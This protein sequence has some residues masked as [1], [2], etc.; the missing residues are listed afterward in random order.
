MHL[1][2]E[3]DNKPFRLFVQRTWHAMQKNLSLTP[4]EARVARL[5]SDHPEVGLFFPGQEIDISVSYAPG[6]HNPFL[7]LAA[8]R[9]VQQQI[10]QEK[11]AG[12]QQLYANLLGARLS[13]PEARSRMASAYLEWY[14]VAREEPGSHSDEAY[15]LSLQEHIGDPNTFNDPFAFAVPGQ[16][17]SPS[18][19]YMG[20]VFDKA[21]AALRARMYE[22]IS[23]VSLS[24]EMLLADIL[25]RLPREWVQAT[26][27]YWRLPKRRLKR[28]SIKD[29]CRWFAAP[30]AAEAFNSALSENEQSCL[31]HMFLHGG[32]LEYDPLAVQFGDERGDDYW[33]SKNPPTSIIGQLRLKGVL[34]VGRDL[35]DGRQVK[36]ALI[37]ADLQDLLREAVKDE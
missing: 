33:W 20:D 15:L 10:V 3:L 12:M 23:S 8:L 34:F 18:G 13:E 11:P 5:I 30:D 7:F 29:I 17:D 4:L 2:E 14:L 9:E 21:Y 24:P 26:A 1:P 19:A 22:E 32:R 35:L 16:H 28:D 25:A 37:P 31:A 6:D 27:N 36:T